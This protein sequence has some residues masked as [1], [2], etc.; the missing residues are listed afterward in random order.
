MLPQRDPA[1]FGI[2]RTA[3]PLQD[4]FVRI[5]APGHLCDMDRCLSLTSH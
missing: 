3:A 4:D 2:R 1:Q 5:G